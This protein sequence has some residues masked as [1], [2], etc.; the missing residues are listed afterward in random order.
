MRAPT[1]CCPWRRLWARDSWDLL[2]PLCNASRDIAV[3]AR[4]THL[5]PEKTNKNKTFAIRLLESVCGGRDRWAVDAAKASK[6]S[7]LRARL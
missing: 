1:W 7:L 2:W 6:N 5:G 3:D 4:V